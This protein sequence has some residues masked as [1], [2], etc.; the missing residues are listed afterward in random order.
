MN[1]KG[2]T[3]KAI[4]D[5]VREVGALQQCAEQEY[6]PVV[7]AILSTGSRDAAHIERT[8]DGL[9]DFCGH[10]P[11]LAMFKQLCHHYGAIDPAAAF[12]YVNAYRECWGEEKR[13]G[14]G[15]HE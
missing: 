10:E 1:P 7:D 14:E 9:L 8:L 12:D 3:D 5:L 13:A 4:I 15:H 6:R 11:V 2:I